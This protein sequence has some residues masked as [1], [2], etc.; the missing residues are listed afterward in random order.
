MGG[1]ERVEGGGGQGTNCIQL[2]TVFP[3]FHQNSR[4]MRITAF[5]LKFCY[6]R[7]QSCLKKREKCLG[8]TVTECYMFFTKVKL[9]EVATF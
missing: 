9:T 7:R 8:T 4:S 6:N 3:S 1:V 2:K 5:Q